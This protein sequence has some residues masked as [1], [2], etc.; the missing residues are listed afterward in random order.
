MSFETVGALEQ[1]EP[2][3]PLL[4]AHDSPCPLGPIDDQKRP[5][6]ELVICEQKTRNRKREKDETNKGR[7]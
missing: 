2:R 1:A 6:V 5:R 7:G 4:V 3:A